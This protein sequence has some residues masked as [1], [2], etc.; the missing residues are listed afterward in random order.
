[1]IYLGLQQAEVEQQ[2]ANAGLYQ[3]RAFIQVDS[4]EN[5]PYLIL[6]DPYHIAW[7][8]V[9]HNL[10]QM[11]FEIESQE[12]ESG[13]LGE[14]VFNVKAL[15]REDAE[16]GGF[17][18]FVSTPETRERKI[19][20]VLSQESHDLTRVNIENAKGEF[21]TSPEGDEFLRLLYRRLR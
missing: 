5:S 20:L 11:N 2:V 3:P 15:V 19:V 16:E 14:G 7:N 10:E 12:F 17:F 6:K 21:D 4:E 1:M 13:F 8:R 18:S 9:L